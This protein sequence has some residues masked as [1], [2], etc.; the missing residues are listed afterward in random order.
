M[1]NKKN[2][3]FFIDL[4]GTFLD[5]GYKISKI[6]KK[7]IEKAIEKGW[8]INIIT[9][10]SKSKI[11]NI[12]NEIKINGYIITSSG[13]LIEKNQKVIFKN[14][15]NKKQVFDLINNNLENLFLIE[16]DTGSFSNKPSFFF[17]K[18]KVEKIKKID[19]FD[20]SNILCVF[21][22]KKPKNINNQLTITEWMISENEKLFIVSRK[23]NNKFQ[24]FEFIKKIEK[25]DYVVS[26]GNGRTDIDILKNS[27]LGIA[28]KNSHPQVLK[29]INKISNY[30]NNN[31]VVGRE[32]LNIIKK[33]K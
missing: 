1:E 12:I 23:K 8:K 27:D 25:Y 32:I 13:L 9:G 17:E 14:H 16:S 15:I 30:T 21:F 11:K 31:S 29:S 6:N 3:A 33:Q 20:W 4:D 26:F 22:Y 18:I 10:K 19:D 28:V 5:D 2:K 7:A 24:T